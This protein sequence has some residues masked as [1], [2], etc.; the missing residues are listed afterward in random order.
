MKELLEI[1]NDLKCPKNLEN[2]FSHFMY[3]NCEGILESLKPELYKHKC[4]LTINDEMVM[5]GERYYMVATVTIKNESGEEIS[6]KG[7]AME[8]TAM[9][10]M[11]SPQITGS[12]SSYA[13]KYAL[14]AL[15]LIDDSQD[16]DDFDKEGNNNDK[17]NKR[18]TKTQTSP[19]PHPAL[20]QELM[21]A[22]DD[23]KRAPSFEELMV[24]WSKYANTFGNNPEF[25]EIMKQMRVK[26]N[27]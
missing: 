10:G 4:I 3:R 6:A 7:Y 18:A 22:I 17:S 8:P 20:N 2:K 12:C 27:K 25:M 1:R 24:V 19:A 14:N 11:S 21:V 9:G 23:A 16:P 15:F 13:R 5:I 26:F